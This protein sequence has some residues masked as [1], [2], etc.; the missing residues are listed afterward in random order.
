[1]ELALEE[2]VELSVLWC[3]LAVKNGEGVWG[4]PGLLDEDLSKTD[5]I[6]V[7]LKGLGEIDH[8]IGSVLVCAGPGSSEEG[9][10]CVDRDFTALGTST[11]GLAG[12][13]PLGSRVGND[14]S[15]TLS[16]GDWG[17]IDCSDSKRES[18]NVLDGDH[19]EL[20]EWSGKEGVVK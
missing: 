3:L 19:R 17:S 11:S 2:A 12:L 8:L 7:V 14:L 9:A 13:D 16:L 5:N 1:L 15:N 10:E 20:K 6:G 4:V 18:D